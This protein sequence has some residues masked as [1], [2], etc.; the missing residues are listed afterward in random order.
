[1]WRE[2]QHFCWFMIKN[3][4]G[5]TIKQIGNSENTLFEMSGSLEHK[6]DAVVDDDD[7]DDDDEDDD[8][9]CAVAAL[10]CC[11]DVT[12]TGLS[13]IIALPLLPI[14]SLTWSYIDFSQPVSVGA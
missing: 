12:M 8:G 2:K 6:F 9:L 14:R 10:P 1:M 11:G 3:Y 7:E 5:I 13:L 4:G